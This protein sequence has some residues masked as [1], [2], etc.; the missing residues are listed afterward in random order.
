MNV[1][2]P[3]NPIFAHS[4]NKIIVT[5][6][7][8]YLDFTFD[9][10]VR[11]DTI[12]WENRIYAYNGRCELDLSEILKTFYYRYSQPVPVE[13]IQI[14]NGDNNLNG[15]ELKIL[16]TDFSANSEELNYKIINGALQDS[17][18]FDAAEDQYLNQIQLRFQGF[19]ADVTK[20]DTTDVVRT[21][22]NGTFPAIKKCKGVYVAWLNKYGAYDYYLFDGHSE[23]DINSGNIETFRGYSLGKKSN[24]VVKVRANVIEDME[25]F[26]VQ[27]VSPQITAKKITEA[28]MSI[29]ESPEV[30]IFRISDQTFTSGG[31]FNIDFNADFLINP[32]WMIA[33]K[34]IK[35]KS[36]TGNNRLRYRYRTTPIDFDLT[37]PDEYNITAI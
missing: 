6:V 33:G 22:G 32:F 18:T 16:M 13:T 8:T 1:I 24:R 29:I 26:S 37:L 21:P 28:L 23:L 4:D 19:P 25:R 7:D 11:G 9:V 3:I 30:Y 2:K 20:W 31:D 27:K 14:L 10:Y 34:F 5:E 35:V 15:G 12:F 36:V 17:E